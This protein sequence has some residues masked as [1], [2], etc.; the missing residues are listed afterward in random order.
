[1]Q[2]DKIKDLKAQWPAHSVPQ[3]ML[4]LVEELEDELEH[5]LLEAGFCSD[6]PLTTL[7]NRGE[8]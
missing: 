8:S 2:E 5:V 4:M 7:D 1:M 6:Q 3:S